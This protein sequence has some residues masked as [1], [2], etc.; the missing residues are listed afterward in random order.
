[1]VRSPVERPGSLMFEEGETDM[2][3]KLAE[4]QSA[5]SRLYFKTREPGPS[6]M[7]IYKVRSMSVASS[8]ASQLL[9][10][11]KVQDYLAELQAKADDESVAD[12]LERRQRLTEFIREEI[13]SAKGTIIRT[14]NI[15]AIDT[16][17]KMD[18]IGTAA[19]NIDARSI[20]FGAE[21]GND[22]KTTLISLLDR[23]A[24]RVRENEVDGESDPGA[25]E[26]TTV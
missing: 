6:Y 17:N 15:S 3:R 14:G 19:F 18:G 22:P 5:W 11:I 7:E 10:N 20:H 26:G 16:L 1:M 12:V 2:A 4:K 9:K 13:I 25:I 24:S 21:E 23:I 8:G